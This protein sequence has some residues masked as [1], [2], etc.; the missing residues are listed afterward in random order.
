MFVKESSSPEGALD[1]FYDLAATL[2][3]SGIPQVHLGKL[4][5]IW[6]QRRDVPARLHPFAAAAFFAGFTGLPKPNV[7]TTLS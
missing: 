3:D 5:R 4:E 1:R 2:R 6:L 7:N